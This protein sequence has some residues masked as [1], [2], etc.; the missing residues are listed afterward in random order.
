LKSTLFLLA[1]FTLAASS[2]SAGPLIYL[3]SG[4]TNNGFRVDY[5]VGVTSFAILSRGYPV[6]VT[7][8][9]IELHERDD[10]ASGGREYNSNG[11]ATGVTWAGHNTLGISQLLDGTTDGTHYYAIQCCSGGTN[12]VWQADAQWQNF[13]RLFALPGN[14]ASIAY[15]TA[16]N[17]F[18]INSFGTNL[19][20]YSLT[21]TLLNT[22]TTASRYSGLSYDE[23]TNTLYAYNL[24]TTRQV[25]HLALDGSVLD[26]YANSAINGNIY[27]GEMNMV[28]NAA[29]PSPSPVPEPGTLGMLAAGAGLLVAARR[30]RS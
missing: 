11:V 15:N 14:N 24:T 13:T 16:R 9:N 3:F 25:D 1:A 20:E 4:D 8:G 29:P 22:Y 5:G 7:G 6:V 10:M 27:G 30:F 17:S 12:Y 28:G 19:Y 18:Y 23:A 21:G 26:T 2:A